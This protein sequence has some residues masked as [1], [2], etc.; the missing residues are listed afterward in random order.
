[1]SNYGKSDQAYSS[2]QL[3]KNL[4]WLL[5]LAEIKKTDGRLPRIHDFRHSF[6]VN[7]LLRWYRDGIDVQAK[8]PYL[9][10]WMGHVSIFSTYHYLHFIEP[11]RSLAGRRFADCYSSLVRSLSEQEGGRR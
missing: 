8:L 1:V 4:G 2:I 6:A 5:S 3:R 11:L 7:A 9:A 10:A